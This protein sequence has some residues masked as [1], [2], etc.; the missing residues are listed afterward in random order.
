MIN[1]NFII[2]LLSLFFILI[3]STEVVSKDN[4]Y[5]L[6][7]KTTLKSSSLVNSKEINLGDLFTNTGGKSEIIVAYA[8]PPGKRA[9]FDYNWLYRVARAYKLSWRPNSKHQRIIVERESVIIDKNQIAE[10]LLEHLSGFGVEN[11]LE[12]EFSNRTLRLHIPSEEIAEVGFD[13]LNYNHLQILL[14]WN[15]LMMSKDILKYLN[16]QSRLYFL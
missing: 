16:P 1:K 6:Q 8:P 12:V 2:C 4:T 5:N 14:L 11:D 7:E 13:S 10:E 9:I 15:L 3:E